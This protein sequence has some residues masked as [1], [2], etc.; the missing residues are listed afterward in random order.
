VRLGR[1]FVCAGLVFVSARRISDGSHRPRGDE[2]CRTFL[3]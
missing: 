1:M 3:P 2:W